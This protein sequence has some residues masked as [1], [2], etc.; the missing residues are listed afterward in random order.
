MSSDVDTHTHK[1]PH[2]WWILLR[3][4]KML[5]PLYTLSFILGP[6]SVIKLC[7]PFPC[8]NHHSYFYVPVMLG[9]L[10]FCIFACIIWN[11]VQFSWLGQY[12]RSRVCPGTYCKV[13]HSHLFTSGTESALSWIQNNDCWRT[14]EFHSRHD[15]WLVWFTMLCI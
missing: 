5:L 9:F 2:H 15:L 6:C 8:C 13:L 7:N 12:P 4:V 11:H 3:C 10:S 14:M 1:N